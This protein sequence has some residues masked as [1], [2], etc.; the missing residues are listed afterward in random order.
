MPKEQSVL[1]VFEG[2]SAWYA[3]DL[4][5]SNEW[6]YQL[7]DDDIEEVDDQVNF[8]APPPLAHIQPTRLPAAR[9]W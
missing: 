6:I 5:D 4:Q 1:D 2:P 8:S 3:R 9:P 7:T